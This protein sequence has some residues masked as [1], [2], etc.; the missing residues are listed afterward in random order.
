MNQFVTRKNIIIAVLV[1]VGI[2]TIILVI[3]FLTIYFSERAV[4]FTL[5]SN[6]KSIAIT[7]ENPS[8]CDDNCDSLVKF[9][10]TNSGELR[11]LDGEYYVIPTGDN[12]DTAAIPIIVSKETAAFEINPDYSQEYL[13]SLL[14]SE[15]ATIQQVLTSSF[16]VIANRYLILDGSLYQQGNWYAT[17]L[18]PIGIDDSDVYY[19]VLHKVDG[20]WQVVA[21]PSLYLAYADY[22][23][24]PT[25]ILYDINTGNL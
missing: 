16:P 22:P 1:G 3:H 12:L 23:T 25:T 4:T 7:Q 14:R 5:S 11:L 18:T 13:A 17:A 20:K 19:T 10:L 21:R 15:L 24:I 8:E 9:S 2:T 6:I